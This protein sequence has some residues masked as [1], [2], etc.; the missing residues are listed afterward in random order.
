[1][2][3]RLKNI[4]GQN[5]NILK[6]ILGAFFVKGGA[7]VVSFL[8]L[9]AYLNYFNNQTVLGVWYTILSVLN[10]VLTFD[11]GLGNGLRNKLPIALKEN[12]TRLAKQYVSSTYISVSMFSFLLLLIS[13]ISFSYINWNSIL[14][15]DSSLLSNET[16]STSMKIVFLGIIIQFVLKLISSVLYAIQKSALVNFLALLSN[17]LILLALYI[18]PSQTLEEN[19][20]QMSWVNVLAANAPLLVATILLFTKSLKEI[21]PNLKYFCKA[22]ARDIFQIGITI[23]WLQMVFMILSSMNEFLI[24]QFTSPEDVLTYQ[25]YN[26][27]YNSISS[28]FTLALIPIW[29][30]VTK[31]QAENNYNWIKK[32]YKLLM[33]LAFGVLIVNLTIIPFLQP[34]VNIW[35]GKNS[36]SINY[37]IAILFSISNFIFVFHNVNT[38]ISNGMSYFK[39]QFIWMTLAG[40]INIPL[41]YVSIQVFDS[42]IGVVVANIIA[43]LPYQIFGPYYCMK[44]LSN[45]MRTNNSYNL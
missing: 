29:S 20:I 13:Q 38:S 24:S 39:T 25:V 37:Q 4:S 30:A 18:L 36:I 35:L 28:L 17:C 33:M 32:L 1:M 11:L 27:V 6:N 45:R 9:P 43:L 16:L 40:I 31:A 14:N 34:F 41:A 2:F 21:R 15:V 5:K 8:I 7:M 3:S 22:Y 19:L 23:L 10:W 42:W 44:F 26:K 12:D